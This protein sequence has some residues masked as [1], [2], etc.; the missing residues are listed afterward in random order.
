MHEVHDKA[1]ELEAYALEV[2]VVVVGLGDGGVDVGG[3][4]EDAEVLRDGAD[5]GG[6]GAA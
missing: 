3:V 4:S 5:E 2:E 1:G 6:G